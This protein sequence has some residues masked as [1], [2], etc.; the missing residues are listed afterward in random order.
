MKDSDQIRIWQQGTRLWLSYDNQ[1]GQRFSL[2]PEIPFWQSATIAITAGLLFQKYQVSIQ[3]VYSSS[4]SKPE[5]NIPKIEA[6][7]QPKPLKMN[8]LF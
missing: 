4:T 1:A 7:V 2:I 5:G 3:Y 8:A 6:S